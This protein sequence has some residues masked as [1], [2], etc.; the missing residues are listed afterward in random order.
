MRVH[1]AFHVRRR[2]PE[3]YWN[4]K[5]PHKLPPRKEPLNVIRLP[6]LGYME[7]TV[8]LPVTKAM[9]KC[10]QFKPK[11]PFLTTTQSALIYIAYH[12]K[13]KTAGLVTYSYPMPTIAVINLTESYLHYD[14][15]YIFKNSFTFLYIGVISSLCFKK[16]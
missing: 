5:L 1:V 9:H 16:T 12:L 13:G 6:M 14:F 8:S 7:E 11:Y 15:L 3:T 2:L 4:L 10:G